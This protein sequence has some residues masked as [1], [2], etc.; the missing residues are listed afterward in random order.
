MP[1]AFVFPGQGSQEIGMG[2]SL[3]DGF[4]SLR[5]HFDMADSVSGLEVTRTMFEGPEERLMSTDVTQPALYTHSLAVHSILAGRRIDADVFAGHSLGEFS[6]LAAAGVFSVE[7]GMRLVAKRGSLMAQAREGTMA[8]ILGLADEAIIS[9]CEEIADVWP[10]NFN[11]EGQVVISGSPAGIEKAMARAKE[12]GA[13]KALPLAVSG[14]FHT[15]F[16]QKAADEFRAYLDGFEFGAP[17]GNV[18]PNVTGEATQ[19]PGD[20]KELLAKQLTS[21]VRWTKT[22]QTLAALGVTEVYEL[23]PGKVLC[24]L[25]KRGMPG[26]SCTSLGSVEDIDSLKA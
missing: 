9:M 14:A 22:M 3:Y 5:P 4:E 10:A 11:S 17:K 20:I 13:K 12:L 7:D 18:I 6:A 19:N 24:G 2:K 16:M 25:I 21:P 1:K 8:A 15:P 26:S 23:G